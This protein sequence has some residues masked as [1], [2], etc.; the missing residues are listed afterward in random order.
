[1]SPRL[2]LPWLGEDPRAPFPDPAGALRHPNGLLAAGG[3]LSVPRLLAAYAQGIFPWYGPGEPILWWSPDPRC[4]FHT[5]RMHLPRR[6]ARSFRASPWTV[7][8]D[9]DFG[10]VIDACAA[11]RPGAQGTWI[12]REM[13]EAYLALH[14]AGFAHSIEVFDGAERVGGLYGVALGRMFF[15]ESMYSARSGGSKA[16]LFALARRLREWGWPL[17]DAQVP[18]AHLFTLGAQ[19]MPRASFLRQ[20]PS[21]VLAEAPAGDWRARFG[22]LPVAALARP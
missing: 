22:T 6:Q 10:A 15:A 4:V 21:L 18:S 17:L 19:E 12:V 5:D 1:M 16:A 14:E 20:L 11:P 13:R 8:A 3:D 7:V 9:R 2:R